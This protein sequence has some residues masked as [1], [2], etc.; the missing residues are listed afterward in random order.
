MAASVVAAHNHVLRRWL[1][2]DTVD[3]LGEVDTAMAQVVDL[4]NPD[5]L[6]TSGPGGGSTIVVLQA[7]YRV[8]EILPALRKAIDSA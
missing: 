2:G 1:R 8:E 7:P 5:A 6:G 4:F 3:P